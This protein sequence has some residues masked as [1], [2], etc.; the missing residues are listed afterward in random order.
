MTVDLFFVLVAA[1]W[2]L[3]NMPRRGRSRSYG[4]KGVDHNESEKKDE[5]CE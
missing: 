4:V 3:K 5:A 2:V 1:I